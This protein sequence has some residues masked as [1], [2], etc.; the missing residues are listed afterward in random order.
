VVVLLVDAELDF[1]SGV[2]VAKTQN[3][4][5]NVARLKL[6]DELA[7]VL[8]ESTEEIRHDL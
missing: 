2:R 4:A 8:A 5:V 7:A 6:L 1:S 3:G